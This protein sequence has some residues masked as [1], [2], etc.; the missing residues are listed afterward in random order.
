[1]HLRSLDRFFDGSGADQM[2]R[3][4]PRGVAI[5]PAKRAAGLPSAA[6]ET[7][8][9]D[10]PNSKIAFNFSRSIHPAT[11]AQ[12]TDGGLSWFLDSDNVNAHP[13]VRECF[14]GVRAHL[15]LNDLREAMLDDME[16]H[17]RP[18][19]GG[20][21]NFRNALSASFDGAFSP[22]ALYA[23]LRQPASEKI[24]YE[25]F[26][27]MC[28]RFAG[29]VPKNANATDPTGNGPIHDNPTLASTGRVTVANNGEKAWHFG[30][31]IYFRVVPSNKAAVI[32]G[33]G[34]E[35]VRLGGGG[36]RLSRVVAEAFALDFDLPVSYIAP[37]DV[38]HRGYVPAGVA[39]PGVGPVAFQNWLDGT[40]FA[41][42]RRV[43]LLQVFVNRQRSMRRVGFV[44]TH[45]MAYCRVGETT[46]VS[47]HA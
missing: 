33:P 18:V 19:A 2:L 13:S 23:L 31:E 4:T 14:N 47:I 34:N 1:M 38:A 22:A 8:L 43:K 6:D 7:E 32:D 39:L 41:A 9:A 29:V 11:D 10:E 37:D 30:D 44:G 42:N 20:V 17:I 25:L 46:C 3:H 35:V 5:V 45:M 24:R 26:S 40:V 16:V 21:P 36:T 27:V 28:A 15:V 12:F